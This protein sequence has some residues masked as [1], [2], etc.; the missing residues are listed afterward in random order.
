M[1][2]AMGRLLGV[3]VAALGMAAFINS[4]EGNSIYAPNPPTV[5]PVGS[6]FRWDYDIVVSQGSQVDSGDGFTIYDFG[7]FVGVSGILPTGWSL[8]SSQTNAPDYLTDTRATTD[9]P[10]ITD[11]ILKYTGSTTGSTLINT[12]LGTFSF[13]STAGTRADSFFESKDHTIFNDVAQADDHN[14]QV[15]VGVPV[16]AALW[17]GLGLLGALFTSKVTRSKK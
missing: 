7:G 14:T 15:P 1:K 3:G 8:D 11:L 10:G 6:N 13:L 16:P 9:N 17:G 2:K 5:T 4:A 12:P